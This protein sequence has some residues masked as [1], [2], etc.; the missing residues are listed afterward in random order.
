MGENFPFCT[1]QRI[2]STLIASGEIPIQLR[3]LKGVSSS[4]ERE[5]HNVVE[6]NSLVRV[7]RVQLCQSN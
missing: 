4:R 6:Q 3:H 2:G 1:R 7:I 5:V